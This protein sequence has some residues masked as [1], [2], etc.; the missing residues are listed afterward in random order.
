[1][2]NILRKLN[3][4]LEK[5]FIYREEVDFKIL[6]SFIL[7]FVVFL[8]L[9]ILKPFGLHVL[10]NNLFYYFAGYGVVTTCSLLFLYFVVNPMF[11]KY[12][13][14]E[15]WNIKKEILLIIYLV[16][17]IGSISWLYHKEV[18]IDYTDSNKFTYLSF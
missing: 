6:I 16:F 13:S 17:F 2:T 18:G 4:W 5:P 3:N 12:Y 7:G 9:Y 10:E 14:N 1:M 15:T 8:I 11:P